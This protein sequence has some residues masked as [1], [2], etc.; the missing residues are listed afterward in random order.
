M[1]ILWIGYLASMFTRFAISRKRE[2]MADAGAIEMTKNPEGMMRA[3]MRISGRDRIPETTEDIAFMCIEN[4]KPFLGLF[5]TH[6]PIDKRIEA[7]SQTTGTPVPS[8]QPRAPK[9]EQISN[10]PQQNPWLTRSRGFRQKQ[11]P[12]T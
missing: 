6:P 8:I 7:I 5:A 1:V 9:E 11:N 4:T 10:E 12:W 2:Y 3:L